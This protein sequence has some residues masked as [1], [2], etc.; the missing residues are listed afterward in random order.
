M[1]S[2][3]VISLI[4][5]LKLDGSF[6]IMHSWGDKNVCITNLNKI[7]PHFKHETAVYNSAVM[8]S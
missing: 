4:N 5:W 6:T 3:D 8:V 1:K 7:T 2:H